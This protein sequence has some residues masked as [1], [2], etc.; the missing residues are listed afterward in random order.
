MEEATDKGFPA[1]C[2]MALDLHWQQYL[3]Y[4][5]RNTSFSQNVG[6]VAMN[7]V[8]NRF[9]VQQA[10]F[11]YRMWSVSKLAALISIMPQSVY[12]AVRQL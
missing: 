10:Y 5:R 9:S 3:A 12:W 1:L 11:P 2:V 6:L 7:K 8:V 4:F